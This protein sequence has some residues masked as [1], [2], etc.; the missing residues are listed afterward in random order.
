M[1]PLRPVPT[2]HNIAVSIESSTADR[3]DRCGIPRQLADWQSGCGKDGCSLQDDCPAV[4]V[5]KR[6]LIDPIVTKLQGS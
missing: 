2:G 3:R 6:L 5:L 1:G 4:P